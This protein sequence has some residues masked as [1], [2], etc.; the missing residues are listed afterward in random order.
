METIAH[1][2]AAKYFCPE[3]DF[4]LDIG[5]QDIKCF[6]VVVLPQSIPSHASP[7]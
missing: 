5:G 3:V 4:I 7:V 6:F 2:T 1:Y